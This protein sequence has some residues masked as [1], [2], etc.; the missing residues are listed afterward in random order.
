M[1]A[2]TRAGV[3]DLADRLTLEYAGAIPPG[4]VLALVFR[5]ERSLVAGGRR[6]PAATRLEVCE[7]VVR[8][9]LTDRLADYSR[10]MSA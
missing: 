5:A 9:M 8:R 2:Q 6:L 4:Q 1:T 3:R 7:Q 10:S